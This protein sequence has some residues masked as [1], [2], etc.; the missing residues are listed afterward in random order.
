M[1]EGVLMGTGSFGNAGS[2]ALG[3]SGSGAAG[4]YRAAASGTTK[5]D[6][7]GWRSKSG[8]APSPVLAG[9]FLRETLAQR[10][11]SGCVAG[12]VT[13]PQVR[14]CYD[15]LFRL[16]VLLNQ[17]RSWNAIERQYGVPGTPGCLAELQN[18]LVHEHAVSGSEPQREIA[19]AATLEFM[20][21][22]IDNN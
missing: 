18:V 4:R 16:S 7:F 14:G 21:A 3:R 9:Q 11:V 12:I 6:F 1:G 13:S 20:L 22:A 5:G 19:A 15:E 8:A 2:G 10:N 17:Q